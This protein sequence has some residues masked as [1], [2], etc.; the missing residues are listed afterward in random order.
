MTS[1]I[2]GRPTYH[3]GVSDDDRLRWDARYRDRAPATRDDVALPRVFQPYAHVF[4][5]TGTALDLACGRGTAALWL[6]ERGLTVRG[7]DVSPV[8]VARA[9]ILAEECG[10]AAR[11]RFDVADLDAGLPPGEAVNVLLCNKFRDPRLDEPM[12]ERLAAGGLLAVSALSRVGASAGPFRAGLGELE[13]AFAA[14]QVIGCGEAD[15]EAW[16]LARR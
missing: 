7:Y 12:V 10:Y 9:R 1:I 13:R 5:I 2:P 3:D 6:A 8:A 15:G 11:C 14:L 16:L 4:P